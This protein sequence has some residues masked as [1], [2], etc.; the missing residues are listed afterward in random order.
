MSLK[1]LHTAYNIQGFIWFLFSK[2]VF[3]NTE[4]IILDSLKI[5]IVIII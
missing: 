5:I 1:Y 4:N 3:E 2:T